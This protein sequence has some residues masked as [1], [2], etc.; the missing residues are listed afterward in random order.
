MLANLDRTKELGYRTRDAFLSG[1]LG[2]GGEIMHEHWMEKKKRS[3]GMSNPNVD[4]WYSLALRN[5]AIGG[6]L[7]GAGGGGFMLF[8]AEDARKLRTT[9]LGCGL[10][11]LKLRMDVEGTSVLTR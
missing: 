6:K 1:R 10:K 7:V 2:I 3:P 4:E 5:G 8:Y 9:M 11:E